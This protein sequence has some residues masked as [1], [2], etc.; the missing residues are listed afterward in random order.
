MWFERK[1]MTN[2][3]IEHIFLR[4]TFVGFV[5][6]NGIFECRELDVL[7]HCPTD[8]PTFISMSHF[9]CKSPQILDMKLSMERKS[10]IN[11]TINKLA[12]HWTSSKLR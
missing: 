8:A 5:T 9:K 1:L 6:S 4:G 2:R 11:L 10:C 3:R 7:S 12:F